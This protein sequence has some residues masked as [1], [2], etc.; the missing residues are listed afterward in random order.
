MNPYNLMNLQ[1]ETNFY[2]G[3]T[4]TGVNQESGSEAWKAYLRRQTNTI[5]RGDK[6]QL[7]QGIKFGMFRNFEISKNIGA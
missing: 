1:T 3:K 2:R 7:A 4:K 5:N 6:L